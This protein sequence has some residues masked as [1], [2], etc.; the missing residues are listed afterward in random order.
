MHRRL[1]Q[2]H[3]ALNGGQGL[4]VLC[5]VITR[6]TAHYLSYTRIYDVRFPLE[7]LIELDP[8]LPEKERCVIFGDEKAQEKA[9][10]MV[11]VIQDP[12]FWPAID[13]YV[14]I[15]SS[16]GLVLIIAMRRMRRHL[17]PLAIAA[18]ISQAAQIHLYQILLIWGLLHLRYSQLVAADDLPVRTAI[19]NALEAH[20]KKADQDAFIA[21]L[22]LNP[23]HKIRPLKAQNSFTLG[24]VYALL[25]R[26]WERFYTERVPVVELWD[27][28]RAYLTESDHFADMQRWQEPVRARAEATVS[29]HPF[30]T[31]NLTY[32]TTR[33][34][35]LIQ[36]RFG[37]RPS[38]RI[39][40][41]ALSF[42]SHAVFSPYARM[43]RHARGYS[44]RSETFSRSC[45]T[46]SVIARFSLLRR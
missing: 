29:S 1:K 35:V 8:T 9:R 14:Q 39:C 16:I 28:V 22:I 6:W 15:Y 44:A 23:F 21:A 33:K 10:H 41:S 45:A 2:K 30:L 13:R 25:S 24:G 38:M 31:V 26:L 3:A 17:K 19:T 11:A 42:G 27:D 43:L 12:L 32:S 36:L 7:A 40:L 18:N 5:A 37:T 20:W 34:Q 4:S 46:V